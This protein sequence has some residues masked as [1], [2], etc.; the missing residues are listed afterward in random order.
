[1]WIP[2]FAGTTFEGVS[3]PDNEAQNAIDLLNDLVAKARKAGA[4]AADAV[5]VAGSARPKSSNARKARIL[6]LGS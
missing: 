5:A 4:D 2:A 6:V 1:M 3:M